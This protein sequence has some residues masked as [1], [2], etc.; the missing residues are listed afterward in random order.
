MP[1]K[2]LEKRRDYQ[3]EY[4]RLQR[5]K[6]G[7]KQNEAKRTIADQNKKAKDIQEALE[8]L[9]EL[10]NSLSPSSGSYC[11]NI[12]HNPGRLIKGI[13]RFS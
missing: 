7:T 1:Y 8:I 9:E 5:G 2:D 3:R 13:P 6:G 11:L 10:D 12:P 4:M